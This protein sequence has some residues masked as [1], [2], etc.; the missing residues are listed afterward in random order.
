MLVSSME[1]SVDENGPRVPVGDLKAGGHVFN[2]LT[3][4]RVQIK[5]TLHRSLRGIRNCDKSLFPV[6]IPP[7]SLR[8]G[9]PIRPIV[10]SP[11]QLLLTNAHDERLGLGR[12]GETRA[13]SVGTGVNFEQMK[14]LAGQ[15]YVVLL[16]EHSTLM[17]CQGL[18][19]RAYTLED[20]CV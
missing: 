7:H 10:T 4:Q 6:V 1:V 20:I 12:V 17:D 19:L 18:L 16:F 15:D 13:D 2:P 9:F 8:G 14:F 5:R 3:Q 11:K